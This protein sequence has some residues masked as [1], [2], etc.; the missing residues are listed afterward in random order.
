MNVCVVGKRMYPVVR[1]AFACVSRD[2][3]SLLRFGGSWMMKASM[4]PFTAMNRSS[5]RARTFLMLKDANRY[6]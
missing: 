4:L 2:G 5:S 1:A 6:A 3:S